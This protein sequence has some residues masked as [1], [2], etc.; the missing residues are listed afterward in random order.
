MTGLAGGRE[1][2]GYVTGIFGFLV[3]GQVAGRA[4]GRKALELAHGGAPVAGLALDG[5]MSAEQGEAVLVLL[6]GGQVDLPTFDGVALLAI[7]AE[8]SSVD[9]GVAISAILAYVGEDPLQMALSA[10]DPLVH[11]AQGVASLV[12][13]KL[14]DS[15]DGAP[16]GVGMAILTRDSQWSVRTPCVPPL[17]QHK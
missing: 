8:F 16:A 6:D 9:V 5:G 1:I 17:S 10:S 13:V 15:A 11:A 14:G 4:L 12:V 7:G 3:I 2:Q